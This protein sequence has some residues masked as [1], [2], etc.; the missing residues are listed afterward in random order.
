MDQL[1]NRTVAVVFAVVRAA[2]VTLLLSGP[3]LA[4][5]RCKADA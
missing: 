3:G 5:V 2:L 4:V 1:S